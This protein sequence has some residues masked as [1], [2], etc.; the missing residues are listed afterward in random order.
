V[1]NEIF[2]LIIFEG[3]EGINS[4]KDNVL[5][6]VQ[7]R[8]YSKALVKRIYVEVAEHGANHLNRK[9]ISLR[10]HGTEMDL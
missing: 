3:I 9:S 5:D 1:R 4:S 8:L 2:N 6:T 7:Y 10:P